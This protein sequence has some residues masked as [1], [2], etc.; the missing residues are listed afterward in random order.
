MSRDDKT[1]V[2]Y[3]P[4]FKMTVAWVPYL[5]IGILPCV[6]TGINTSISY[7][8][9]NSGEDWTCPL[10]FTAVNFILL[11]LCLWSLHLLKNK[12]LSNIKI[13]YSWLKKTEI[14]NEKYQRPNQINIS[15]FHWWATTFY[16]YFTIT[17]HCFQ[18]TAKQHCV[19]G[20]LFCGG[21]TW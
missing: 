11:L 14:S 17:I 1:K 2:G 7:F 20:I 3:E 15:V 8:M 6:Y 9:G 12:F 13:I 19:W 21:L 16:F 5:N 18:F 4:V 10:E